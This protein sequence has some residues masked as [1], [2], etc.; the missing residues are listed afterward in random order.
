MAGGAGN[1]LGSLAAERL[2]VFPEGIDVLGCV[3]VDTQ[4]GFMRLSDDTVVNVSDIHHVS[5]VEAFELEISTQNVGGDGAAKV[6]DV[7]VVPDGWTAVV[8]AGL[9]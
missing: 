6:S 1:D 5:N 7:T 3:I 8:E 2:E 4:T 9:A